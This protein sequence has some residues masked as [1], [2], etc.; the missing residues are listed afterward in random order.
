MTGLLQD[1]YSAEPILVER[2]NRLLGFCRE[3]SPYYHRVI[4]A[5]EV[6]SLAEYAELPLL[7]AD[8][9]RQNTPPRGRD[10]FAGPPRGAFV[11][12]TGGTTGS[13]KYT[14]RNFDDF[15]ENHFAFDGLEVDENDVVANLFMPGIW[16]A[17]TNHEKGLEQRRCTVV[18]IG[19]FGLEEAFLDSSLRTMV[20]TGVN[21]VIGVPS[22]IVRFAQV[23]EQRPEREQLRIR[24]VYTLGEMM[25]DSVYRY[26]RKAF[27]EPRVMS[28]YSSVDCSLMG[29]QDASCAPTEYR[30]LDHVYIEL[31]D[32]DGRLITEPDQPGDV[33]VTLMKE[34]LTPMVRYRIGDAAS[35][36][37][38]ERNDG[39]SRPLL[40]VHGR[41]DDTVIIASV[42]VSLQAVMDIVTAIDGLSP[43]VQMRV[44][45]HGH[46]DHLTIAIETLEAISERQKIEHARQIEQVLINNDSHLKDAIEQRKCEP[47]TIEIVDPGA[48]PRRSKTGK[49]KRIV[50]SRR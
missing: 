36:C 9:L 4:P 43:N 48:L 2:L 44:D 16:G 5:R 7:D 42:H 47:V 39:C 23:L 10:L 31:L 11:F 24:K 32:R 46:R 35:F 12:S 20:D 6:A 8:L 37:A 17:Y 15:G 14:F 18:P 41:N 49:I 19:A 25:Y 13:P 21:M 28:V 50:D 1:F 22:T 33:I 38:V 3:N 27:D 26:L 29:V 45:K 30:V 40:R 34:R